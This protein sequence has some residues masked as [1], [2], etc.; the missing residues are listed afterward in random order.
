MSRQWFLK[1]QES[2]KYKP[3]YPS[4]FNPAKVA[5]NRSVG[6]AI[7]DALL[8][9]RYDVDLN[10]AG[11]NPDYAGVNCDGSITIVD[12]LLIARRYVE[13]IGGF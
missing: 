11:F 3:D 7:V 6:I 5:V 9:A 2:V 12:A 10:P 4:G 8:T 1:M 13:L